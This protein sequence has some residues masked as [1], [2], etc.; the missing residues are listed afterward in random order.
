MIFQNLHLRASITYSYVYKHD[1]FSD[2]ELKKVI[3]YCDGLQV[4]KASVATPSKTT[5]SN[6]RVSEV[7]F[8]ERDQENAWIFDKINYELE[9]MNANY[10][11]FDLYGYDEIQF[12]KYGPN[13]KYDWHMDMFMGDNHTDASTMIPRKLSASIL[14]NDDFKGGEFQVSEGKTEPLTVEMR[15]GSL[16]AFPSFMVHRVKAVESGVRKSLVVWVKGPKFK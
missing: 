2:E 11:G 13:G 8:F 15:A 14:L 1:I 10:Y 9:V 12:G 5:F 4:E 3:E 16:V 6:I 7:S